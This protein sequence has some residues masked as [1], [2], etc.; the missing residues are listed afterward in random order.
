[1]VTSP[2]DIPPLCRDPDDDHVVAAALAAGADAIVTGDCDLLDLGRHE[3]VQIMT[4]VCF[5]MCS[6]ADEAITVRCYG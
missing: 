4:R 2:L 6:Q 3:G 5:S 1:M